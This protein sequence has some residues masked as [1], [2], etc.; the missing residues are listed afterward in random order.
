ML[1]PCFSIS[2]INLAGFLRSGLHSCS[3]SS[4]ELQGVFVIRF[5]EMG[6]K[7]RID[8]LYIIEMKA[9]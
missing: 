2:V 7:F 1:V 8:I 9:A 4:E 6:I 5:R 3:G